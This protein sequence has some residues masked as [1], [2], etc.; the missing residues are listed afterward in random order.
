MRLARSRS[1]RILSLNG[2][3]ED[4]S[5]FLAVQEDEDDY[6]KYLRP[7]GLTL[8]GGDNH[9]YLTGEDATL[10]K[11]NKLSA[12][13][14]LVQTLCFFKRHIDDFGEGAVFSESDLAGKCDGDDDS[15]RFLLSAKKSENLRESLGTKIKE[16]TD[17]GYFFLTD[18]ERGKYRV[19]SAIHYLEEIADKIQ[20]PEIEESEKEVPHEGT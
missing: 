12:L 9:Y 20:V 17:K 19:L 7:L 13:I 18:E 1:D 15:E 6:M 2:S 11:V 10:T 3:E 5:L 14:D 4:R 8:V 16:M